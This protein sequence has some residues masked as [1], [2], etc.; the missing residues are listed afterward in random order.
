MSIKNEHAA[1]VLADLRTQYPNTPFLALGQTVWWDEPMKATLRVLLD[2]GGLGGKIVLGVHDTDYFAKA[3]MQLPPGERYA[4]LPHNDGSTR[5]LWS[6]AG[7]I[8]QFL[9]SE[10]FPT[11]Q[12]L[13]RHGVPCHWLAA[14]QG[15]RRQALI[16]EVTE[17]WG[18]RG[19]VFAGSADTV[20]SQLRLEDVTAGIRRMLEWGFDG[21]A[22]AIETAD[23][24]QHAR[25]VAQGLIEACCACCR[26]NPDATLTHLYMAM[27]PR[28]FEELMRRRM[29]RFSVTSTS[30]LLRFTPD[31]ATLPRFEFLDLFL[32]PET[33][34]AAVEAYNR[35]IG[36]TEVYSLDKFG[37]GALPF[38]VV[39]PGRGRGTLRITLRAVHIETS[40]PIRIRLT[41]PIEGVAHLAAVLSEH[42]GERLVVVGKAVA[43]ISML[44]REFVFVFNEAGSM[45]VS[46]TRRMNAALQAQG[47]PVIVH[48]ILRLHYQTWDS[49]A[50]IK[51]VIRLPEPFRAPFGAQALPMSQFS[52]RWRAVVE[53]QQA[54]L[55]VLSGLRGTRKLLGFLADREPG[56]WEC[57]RLEYEQLML[58]LRR[59]R[60]R[61]EPIAEQVRILYSEVA[62]V[63]ARIAETEREM[64]RH[65]RSVMTWTATESDTRSAYAAK[66]A[67]LH[68]Q[69]R[70]IL[71]TI[72]KLKADRLA[73]ER[74]DEVVH[75]RSRLDAIR[76]GAEQARLK[77]VRD[78]LLTVKGL[79]HTDHRPC[80]W[81]IPMVDPS[82]AWF[83]RIAET[84]RAY[85]EPL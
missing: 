6:A 77:L 74:S 47:I 79:P 14:K 58:E 44:A 27:F 62:G 59:H 76:I 18:W 85:T 16:D 67:D 5:D 29:S 20:V 56:R 12:A 26:S 75:L 31:T 53:E 73:A 4:L 78:A 13:T 84:V 60:E 42:L 63:R 64:S 40:Q 7:E 25:H 48:P 54:L 33:R 3:H 52:A 22:G 81:W 82:G 19:L 17:A 1:S 15:D 21:A 36:G 71:E 45:Y 38:D 83:E 61:V 10:C 39:V 72:R 9:G 55:G 8:S 65:Y 57:T 68:R 43:L 49:A 66:L 2:E 50:N 46:R 35:A 11:R 41:R 30:E 80:S 23:T 24:A 34:S 32:R 37:L 69:R 28:L 70:S 51:T